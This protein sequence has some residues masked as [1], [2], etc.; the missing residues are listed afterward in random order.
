MHSG[1][2]TW[3]KTVVAA[4]AFI[5][6]SIP[7]AGLAKKSLKVGVPGD[8][9]SLDP[10][11][12]LSAV[13]IQYSNWVF[14]PLVRCNKQMAFEPR[15]AVSWK[16]LNEFSMRFHL[17]KGVKFHSG[18]PFTA[19]DVRWTFWRLKRSK[20]L[21]RL[22]RHIEDIK[23]IDDHTI[24]IVSKRP[25]SLLL[26]SAAYLFP[27]DR[28]YYRG[29]DA[30]GHYKDAIDKHKPSF[31]QQNESGTGAFR[32][33]LREKNE[34][35]VL[36]RFDDY[37]DQKT[38][39]NTDRL[40]VYPI[41][42]GTDRVKALFSGK[43]DV[44]F[45]VPIEK[46]KRVKNST[47]AKLFI[48]S[49]DRIVLIQLNQSRRPEFKDVRVRQAIIHAIDGKKLNRKI[50]QRAGN[51]ACQLSPPGY[52]GH[53]AELKPRYNLRKARS[54]MKQA[55]LKNGFECTLIVPNGRYLQDVQIGEAL[56]KM[57]AKIKIKVQLK[58]L[59]NFEYW[60]AF[61]GRT[62]D[63]Q[64]IGWRGETLDSGGFAE[65][66]AMC[67]QKKT[68]DGLFNSGNYCNAK[69][70]ALVR[71]AR[72]TIEPAVRS[73]IL[74]KVERLLYAD[75]AFVPLHW[76]NY[77]YAARKG[78]DLAPVLNLMNIPYLSDLVVD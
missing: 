63:M 67:P 42:E 28:R 49:G 57:L 59:F 23:I 76:Q 41:K 73:R 4:L 64:M 24:D 13:M 20:A 48:Q 21:P 50:L 5:I 44:I 45:E 2:K 51:V 37:W 58:K 14:D 33:V 68:D 53:V 31:A 22:L 43:V 10:Q 74:K 18:N 72:S 8:L 26:N 12:E 36:E 35:T 71:Q 19:D 38:S 39:G 11:V 66:L 52:N 3:T 54:L 70:D 29:L 16:R 9:V 65:L 47:T 30:Q 78:I 15:L 1:N 32:V 7:V 69:V 56:V 25:N 61:D 60:P 6:L 77:A 27:M 40:I 55:G 17:R 34:M 62:A 75:A 46:F